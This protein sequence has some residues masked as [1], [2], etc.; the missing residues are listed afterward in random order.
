MSETLCGTEGTEPRSSA[1]VDA[2]SGAD[3]QA[4]DLASGGAR[5]L[6]VYE[7]VRVRFR[8]EL[9]ARW[10]A[11]F[12][13]LEVAWVYEP[14]P[15]VN[16]AGHSITPAFWLP[17]QRIWFDAQDDSYQLVSWWMQ[18]AGAVHGYTGED[19]KEI[20]PDMPSGWLAP[21]PI[22]DR[23]KGAALLCTRSS[24]F[25][26]VTDLRGA[27]W[28][29][30]GDAARLWTCM[31]EGYLWTLCPVCGWLGAEWDGLADRLECGCLAHSSQEKNAD[32]PR[33]LAAYQA[34][35]DADVR[36][37]AGGLLQ[38]GYGGQGAGRMFEREGLVARQGAALAE[39]RCVGQCQSLAEV[40]LGE[41]PPGAYV[42]AGGEGLCGA[43]PG[44]VCEGCGELP[45]PEAGGACR[46][47]EPQRLWSLEQAKKVLNEMAV[48]L[49]RALGLPIREVH[50][51][52]NHAMDV[53]GREMAR[54]EHL[55]V[56]L[57]RAQEWLA[58]LTA[59]QP[60]PGRFTRLSEEDVCRLDGAEARQEI[61]AR[62]GTVSW[63]VR[64]PIPFVQARLNRIVGIANRRRQADDE[65]LRE[66]LRQ[67]QAWLSDPDSYHRPQQPDPDSAGQR[68]P[69]EPD[70]P[71]PGDR[72]P[73]TGEPGCIPRPGAAIVA[74]SPSL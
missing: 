7:R 39:Q 3:Q 65:Q 70:V 11:F 48:E 14:R 37:L 23:W 44:F 34:A 52:L 32:D 53:R 26:Q 67:V 42:E 64:Q 9:H 28:W 40:M 17:R 50:T 19:L 6:V 4:G 35:A 47:C 57:S 66:G 43:C 68:P 12:D 31:D 25:P 59:F 60:V 49:S 55:A 56:G 74:A 58:D 24:P 45:T 33:L 54:L 1:A 8:T 62:I 30:P 13:A 21:F 46:V 38:P 16:Q 41:L 20:A 61:A 15:F 72:L 69:G 27:T 36:S 63:R 22:A 5:S 29:Q 73:P 10:S 2:R 18:F 51:A 71:R